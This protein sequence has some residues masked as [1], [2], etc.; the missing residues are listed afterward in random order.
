MGLEDFPS[1][2]LVDILS[3]VGDST[4]LARCRL[5]CRTL[6]SL[7]YE[8]RSIR[9]FCSRERALRSSVPGTVDLHPAFKSVV[10]NL[11]SL[12]SSVHSPLSLSLAAERPDCVPAGEIDDGDELY[13]TDSPFLSRWIPLISA[14]L[15]SLSIHD[16]WLQSCWRPSRALPLIS[17]FCSELLN[18]E[19]RNAWLSVKELMPMQTLTSLNLNYIRLDDE[20]LEKVNECFPSLRVLNLIDV[21]GLKEPKIQL[22]QLRTFTWTVS[23][24]VVSLTVDAPKLVEL[25]LTCVEP[26]A[27]HLQTPLLL[28]LDITIKKV[29]V[30]KVDKLHNLRVLR[31]ESSQLGN[32]SQV[33]AESRTIKRLE[34]EL[35]EPACV[36][37]T[38]QCSVSLSDTFPDIEELTIGEKAWFLLPQIVRIKGE[39][40][41][42]KK[43]VVH[44]STTELD[45]AII[46]SKLSILVHSHVC[47][48]VMVIP[49]TAPIEGRV[50]AISKCINDFPNIRWEFVTKE[51][52]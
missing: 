36:I 13:F 49:A 43:L 20:N 32:L 17:I 23:N 3:R 42:L 47:Q 52:K 6:R 39:L 8:A 28:N 40:V 5:T 2:I 18:L 24:F 7:S 34:M 37:N 38:E 14:R 4:D 44:E 41:S 46:S 26:K 11:A 33:F 48:V 10:C 45:G 16:Y 25:K 22:L 19:I 1:P 29:K 35:Y 27:V 51:I 9:L 50:C 21:G 31:V 30:I 15:Q 12:L